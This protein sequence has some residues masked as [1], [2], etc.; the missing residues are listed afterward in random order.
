MFN[1][2]SI[3]GGVLECNF[4]HRRCGRLGVIN[5]I[6]PLYS[7]LPVPYV[8]VRLHVAL[9]SLIGILIRLLAVPQDCGVGDTN[10]IYETPNSLLSIS[11]ERSW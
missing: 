11:V 7:T 4:A 10:K 3:T 6:H 5:Q 2:T 9:W 8:L 1:N